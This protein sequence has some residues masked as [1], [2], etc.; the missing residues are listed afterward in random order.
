MKLDLRNV[1][2]WMFSLFLFAF[3]DSSLSKEPGTIK[4]SFSPGGSTSFMQKLTTIKEK[5]MGAKGQQLDESVSTTKF[6]ITKNGSGWDVLAEPKNISMRRN[7][8]EINNPIVSLLSSAVITYKLDSDGNI[9]DVDGYEPFIDAISKQI[10]PEVFKQLAP[11]L[12]IDVMKAKDI[13]EWNGRI[14]DYVG[15]EVEIGDTFVAE[16]PYQ[17]PNGPTIDYRVQTSISAL[18]PCGE[19][20]CLRIE[21]H[22]DSRADNLAKMT[23]EVVSN[24]SEALSPELSG[25]SSDSNTAIIKGEV[26]RVIDPETMLIYAE[27]SSRTIAMEIDLP[28][29]GLI[30]V[31]TTETRSYE[32]EY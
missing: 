21:Q 12:N 17:I 8:E 5:D 18:V 4:F 32:F 23:G 28:G 25:S 19:K 3:F 22:Y 29:E 16:I 14:G 26:V 31:K 1:S 24:V 9:V 2:R 13:A 6:T 27:N 11:I 7:K 20:K 15:V 30:P 10:P